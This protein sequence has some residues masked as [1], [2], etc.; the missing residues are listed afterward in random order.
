M[1]ASHDH[2]ASEALFTRAK[3]LL[4]G[5]VNSPVRAF[6]SVGG[7]PLFIDHAKGSRIYDV[8]GGEYL[9]FL[10][11]WGPIILGHDHPAIRDAVEQAVGRGLS[12]GAPCPAE[13][14]VAGLMCAMVPGLEMVRMVNSGTEAVMSA[15]RLARAATRRDKVIKFEGCYHGHVDSMLVKAGSGVMTAGIPS[16]SGV[17][18]GAASDTLL[19]TYNDLDSV[20]RLL[21]ENEGEVAAIIVEPVAANMGV[22]PP[23]SGF[24][25]GLRDLCDA[26]GAL[27]VFDEVITGFRLAAGGAQEYFGV[28]A[29][30][31]TFGKVIGGGMPVG[32]YGGSRKLMELVSPAGPVYQAGTLSGNPVAMAAG[33]AQ[34]SLLDA[35]RRIYEHINA[36]GARLASGLSQAA[37]SKAVV[38]GIGSLVC[39]FFSEAPVC[40]YAAA[41]ACDTLAFA[42]YFSGMLAEGVYIA[43]SQFEALFVSAA[44]TDED[45]DFAISAARR[46]FAD[47]EG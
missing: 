21:R 32:A 44:H 23:Q 16:S 13:V 35:D 39:V 40:D 31:L 18:A 27:L 24:L 1:A 15:L 30:L 47:M 28:R 29:D 17:T 20:E 6:R 42:R 26:H 5:G 22:V 12:F 38:Q 4:P 3:E 10:G 8:D 34:L 25:Q 7:Q 36:A 45:I 19:A 2:S 14:D 11:S 41:G 9:D 37:G 46:V 43:P 33:Y